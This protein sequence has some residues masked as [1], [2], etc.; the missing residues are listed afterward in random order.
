[1]A[2]DTRMARPL[3]LGARALGSVT[4]AVSLPASRTGDNQYEFQ[5]T[6]VKH[7]ARRRLQRPLG[8]DF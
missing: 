7:P 5:K 1:M 6:L 8:R 3:G 4:N 2:L